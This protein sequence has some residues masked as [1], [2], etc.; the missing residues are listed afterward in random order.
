MTH[1]EKQTYF[2]FTSLFFICDLKTKKN[3]PFS[4]FYRGGGG[5]AK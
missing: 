5:G 3:V 2:A 4:C 1:Y